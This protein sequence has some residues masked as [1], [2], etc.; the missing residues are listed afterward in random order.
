[1]PCSMY[2]RH[3]GAVPSGRS[4]RGFAAEVVEGVH[5]FLDDVG[6]IP[7]AATEESGVFEDRSVDLLVSELTRGMN[8]GC[9]DG[10]PEGLVV[11]KDVGDA[12]RSAIVFVDRTYLI[13]SMFPDYGNGGLRRW[14]W[15]FDRLWDTKS[16]HGAVWQRT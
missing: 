16:G 4:V 7:D 6:F 10:V 1:M 2:E 13:D 3:T 15:C 5:L 8:G 11:W 14:I 12:A 9:P